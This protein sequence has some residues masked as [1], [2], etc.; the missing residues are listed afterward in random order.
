M[1]AQR[2][3]A[4]RVIL[5]ACAGLL[6]SGCSRLGAMSRVDPLS[7]AVYPG[8]QSRQDPQQSPAG[9]I[10]RLIEGVN[11]FSRGAI[12]LGCFVFPEDA[13]L[14]NP[15]LAY[16]RAFDS[17]FYRNRLASLLLKHSDDVCVEE[18]GRMTSYE[19]TTNTSLSVAN[20]VFTAVANI[21]TGERAAEI[22]TGGANI[23]NASRDHVNAHVYRNQVA[24]AISR[25][26][27]GERTKQ[28]TALQARFPETVKD[29][30][31]DEAIRAANDYHGTCSFYRGLE[32]VI[33]A[34]NE[35]ENLQRH[36]TAIERQ[37]EIDRI[38]REIVQ[39]QAEM[40]RAPRD[41]RDSYQARIEA[42]QDRRG[43]LTGGGVPAAT[44]ET[45]PTTATTGVTAGAPDVS[46]MEADKPEA[47]GAAEPA[48]GTTTASPTA[49][50]QTTGTP[51]TGTE[52][53]DGTSTDEPPPDEG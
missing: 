15:P 6:L 43:Q 1:A 18:M 47:A 51:T 46:G 12:D 5:I 7:V 9:G 34:V 50:P 4:T 25:A 8:G 49:A 45:S 53:A 41:R 10:C 26:I 40:G 28:R 21:V 38:N 33:A 24:Y 39:L 52:P 37:N 19:A 44:I 42:Q 3:S 31:V 2:I 30:T 29:F 36:Q 16:A 32:L 17:Q 14:E 11:S 13:H 35:R 27:T 22:L 20:T 48:G 23:A